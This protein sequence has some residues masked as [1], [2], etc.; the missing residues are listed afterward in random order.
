MVKKIVDMNPYLN[1]GVLKE[2]N[3][4]KRVT[5]SFGSVVWAHEQDLSYDTLYLTGRAL[6]A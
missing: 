5:V 1:K 6:D 3:Y 2:L 4:F